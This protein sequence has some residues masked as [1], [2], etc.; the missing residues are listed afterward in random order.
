[1]A[2]STEGKPTDK[3]VFSYSQL[4]VAE[5]CSRKWYYSYVKRRGFFS[6]AAMQ[7]GSCIHEYFDRIFS[8][9]VRTGG[10]V[11]SL[12]GAEMDEVFNV[13]VEF[14]IEVMLRASSIMQVW[15]QNV[16]N[17]KEFHSLLILASESRLYVPFTLPSGREIYLE[18]VIDV[19]AMDT[20][21]QQLVII[22][23]KSSSQPWKYLSLEVDSQLPLY[24]GALALLGRPVGRA[25]INNVS[26]AKIDPHLL[27]LKGT[28]DQ[29][30]SKTL[31]KKELSGFMH[32][33]GLRL[34]RFLEMHERQV[35]PMKLDRTCGGC[36]YKD[37]CVS[38]LRTSHEDAMK[39][40]ETS[41]DT[42]DSAEQG[43][44]FTLELCEV[45]PKTK[46]LNW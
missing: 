35:Y 38:E 32:Q 39:L 31:S 20:R 16:E 15:L 42:R 14:P 25:M 23:H 40:L 45:K 28:F 27:V 29:R 18:I 13:E 24:M 43:S 44:G 33:L 19:V 6:N 7:L 41:Y 30:L 26:T 12:G 46:E 8:I 37:V 17:M 10:K 5:D 34:D 21:N 36:I 4:G 22:D 9:Y 1:M 11:R 2:Y 3:I